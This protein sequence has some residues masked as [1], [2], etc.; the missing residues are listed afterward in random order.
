M[1]NFGKLFIVGSI[2]CMAALGVTRFL[3]REWM[4][5]M[6]IFL[7]LSIVF[8]GVALV[9][10]RKFLGEFFSMKTTKQ[11]MS[12]GTMILLFFVVLVL[13]NFMSARHIKT[14][15]FSLSGINSLSDQSIKIVKG[16][17]SDMKVIFFYKKGSQGIEEVRK[18][19]RDLL[20]RYQDHSSFV[21]LDY[22]EVNERPD[23]AKQ[24]EVDKG[25]GV[26]FVTYKGRKN[27]IDK[28]DEQELTNAIVRVVKEKVQKVYFVTGHKEYELEDT[29]AEGLSTFKTILEGNGYQ[30]QPL[31][32]S[33]DLKIPADANILALVGPRYDFSELEVNSLLDYMKNGGTL[34]VALE[35]KTL[36]LEKIF[37]TVGLKIN[38]DYVVNQMGLTSK[39]LSYVTIGEGFSPTSPITKVFSKSESTMFNMASSI[40][41][42][43]NIQSGISIDELVKANNAQA[44]NELSENAKG[45]PGDFTIA[46]SVTGKLQEDAAS[47]E[48]RLVVFGDADFLNNQMIMQRAN[49]DL[50]LNSLSYLA[51]D[52]SMIS[53]TPKEPEITKIQLTGD[54]FRLMVL[55]FIIPL[56]LL[57]LSS[58]IF[59]WHRR[60]SA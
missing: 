39:G 45:R 46:A 15:D 40:E 31:N 28:I 12:M 44:L 34:F 7:G 13:A 56:P 11:G 35:N 6:W 3:L 60:R 24:Y 4:P 42:T 20:K 8:L 10:E 41:R 14:F 25:S 59:I 49:R 43:P 54:N 29:Q 17:D 16:L 26:V 1:S 50:A 27:R 2:V 38:T 23:L 55:G 18:Q 9:K 48:F 19:F 21:Q 30:V 36:G 37:S 47:K 33:T 53:V 58:G 22:V 32:F 5:F 57:L 51:Q 52:E